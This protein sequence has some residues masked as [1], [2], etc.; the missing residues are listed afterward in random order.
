MR[1]R[2]A[3]L[4]L[5]C[6]FCLL[7]SMASAQFHQED[8][9]ITAITA[10]STQSSAIIYKPLWATGLL[11]FLDVTAVE[12]PAP[13]L[14]V[15]VQAYSPTTTTYFDW[16]ATT[17][18]ISTISE[19]GVVIAPLGITTGGHYALDEHLVMLPPILR[20]QVVHGNGNWATYVLYAQWMK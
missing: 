16:T 3:F 2:R 9:L 14:E 10:T 17:L 6:C 13:S 20:L 19:T 18:T 12:D 7:P 8:T 4:A 5:I 15:A 11:L 1:L